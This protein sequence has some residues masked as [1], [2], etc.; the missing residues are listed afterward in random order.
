MKKVI[1]GLFLVFICGFVVFGMT[2]DV[3]VPSGSKEDRLI[4]AFTERYNASTE[5]QIET[6]VTNYIKA[7]VLS[8]EE[9]RRI[10]TAKASI[11][12]F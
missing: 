12:A 5:A 8:I 7:V 4:S 1:L 3:N 6:V 9:D 2:I 10:A 11:E